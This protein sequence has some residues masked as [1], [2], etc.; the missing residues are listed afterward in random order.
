MLEGNSLTS[1]KSF[2]LFCFIICAKTSMYFSPVSAYS[3]KYFTRTKLSKGK[4]LSLNSALA[5]LKFLY[6]EWV[7]KFR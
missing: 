7:F 6:E 2:K 4:P 5:C 3:F 1:S